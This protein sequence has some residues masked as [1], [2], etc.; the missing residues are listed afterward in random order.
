MLRYI[1]SLSV[2]RT[3]LADFLSILRGVEIKVQERIVDN[4]DVWV[5][6][7]WCSNS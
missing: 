7:V 4:L 5:L 6:P 3:P 1:E 2:A